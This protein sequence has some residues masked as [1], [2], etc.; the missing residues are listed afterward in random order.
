MKELIAFYQ[1]F[2]CLF[3]F[4]PII[5]FFVKERNTKHKWYEKIIWYLSGI[6]T[7]LFSPIIMPIYL[8]LKCDHN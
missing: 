7:W 1:V 2:A 5:N 6:I 3:M 4:M 8:G